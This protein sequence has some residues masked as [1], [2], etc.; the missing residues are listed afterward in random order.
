MDQ[1]YTIDE[2]KMEIRES[3]EVYLRKDAKGGYLVP[4][5]RRNPFYLVGPPG[6]GKTQMVRAIAQEIGCGFYATSLTHHTRNSILGLPVIRGEEIKYTEYTMPEILAYIEKICRSGQKEGILLLDEF[7]SMP[8]SLVAPMLAFLQNKTIGNHSLPEGWIMILASNPPEYN[9]TARI[10]DAAIMDRV[11]VM[12]I[13]Y[14]REDFFAYAEKKGLHPAIQE[15]LKAHGNMAYICTNEKRGQEIVTARGWEN[16]SDCLYGYE[17]K[18]FPVSCRLVY[19]FIKSENV[20]AQFFQ[21]YTL[22]GS[23]LTSRDI[24]QI[25]DGGETGKAVRRLLDAEFDDK[26]R[27]VN[28]M[29]NCLSERCREGSDAIFDMDLLTTL[30]EVLGAASGKKSCGLNYHEWLSDYLY[31]RRMETGAK[32]LF[33][34]IETDGIDASRLSAVIADREPLILERLNQELG[35][36]AFSQEVLPDGRYCTNEMMMGLVGEKVKKYGEEA[37]KTVAPVNEMISCAIRFVREVSRTES[38]LLSG[39]INMIGK[40]H[41]ILRVLSFRK[42]RDYAEALR[43]LNSHEAA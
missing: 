1:S 23:S 43:H 25:L 3:I 4:Q 17:E 37:E 7:A 11:R 32:V 26:W 16:L 33:D 10:F 22:R 21:Y 27:T 34:R 30:S 20:A 24:Y 5:E 28:L 14:D 42:N 12:E 38:R 35:L 40:D 39:F 15:F 31:E 36:M 19:Q 6:V 29:K 41:E 2:A 18:N 13:Q 9:R 8:E